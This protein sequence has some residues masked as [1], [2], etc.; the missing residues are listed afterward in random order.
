[1]FF[2][3]YIRGHDWQLRNAVPEKLLEQKTSKKKGGGE[4]SCH[5]DGPAYK[6][7]PMAALSKAL[8]TSTAPTLGSWVQT[9]LEEWMCFLVPVQG[10]L[11]NV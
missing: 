2:K 10:I 8:V 6:C 11:S 9:P 7:I 1:M 4:Q 3:P 5:N